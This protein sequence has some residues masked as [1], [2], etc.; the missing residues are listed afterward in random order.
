MT[1]V[2]SIKVFIRMSDDGDWTMTLVPGVADVIVRFDLD[3]SITFEKIALEMSIGQFESL[4]L[5]V[6]GLDIVFPR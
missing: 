5:F 6:R 2:E 1:K 3:S 4:S